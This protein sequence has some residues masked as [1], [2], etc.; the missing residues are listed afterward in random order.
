MVANHLFQAVFF[1]GAGNEL[2]A[3]NVEAGAGVVRDVDEPGFHAERDVLLRGVELHSLRPPK[4]V[5]FFEVFLERKREGHKWMTGLVIIG[6]LC[7]PLLFA[8]AFP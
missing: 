7:P 3:V 4:Y 1:Y 5:D 8:G 2:G 6:V